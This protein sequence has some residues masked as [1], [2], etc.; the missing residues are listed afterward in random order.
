MLSAPVV[1]GGAL[2]VATGLLIYSGYQYY[3]SRSTT[4]ADN[5]T[6]ENTQTSSSSQNKAKTQSNGR[7]KNKLKP[8]PNA[9]GDHTTFKRNPDTGEVT[10]YETWRTNTKN[11]T[12]GFSSEK[13]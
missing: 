7:S 4:Y 1:M 2:I 9:Q 10:N 3:K 12:T 6:N 11:P 8:A 13:V 5:S